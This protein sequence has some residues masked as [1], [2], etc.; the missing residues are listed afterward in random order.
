M[1]ASSA[2]LAPWECEGSEKREAVRGIF[3][4]IAPHYD[5]MNSIM[6]MSLHGMWRQAGLRAVGLRPMD[7]VLDLCCGTGDFLVSALR[8]LGQG[9]KA[10][11]VDFCAPMLSL[12]S[13]KAPQARLALADA[14]RLPFRAGSF[15][16]VTV[17]WGLRNLADLDAGLIEAA[18]V[19]RPGGRIVSVD[20]AVPRN[21]LI[22]GVSRWLGVAVLPRI[23]AMFGSKTAYEY[24]PRSTQAF[25][26]REELAAAFQSAGFRGVG[27]KDLMLG[28][29]CVHWG[30][31]E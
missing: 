12:A 26:T 10:T 14:C 9:G 16:V 27:W 28:N 17:G 22:R 31:K 24:L 21:R 11:G 8:R 4:Q 30:I 20:M 6:S 18:R 19:L 5:R 25:A 13:K 15:D 2:P 3:A 1:S 7:Q 29:I 23:G